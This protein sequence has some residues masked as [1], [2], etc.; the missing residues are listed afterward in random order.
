MENTTTPFEKQLSLWDSDWLDGVELL[1]LSDEDEPETDD[2]YISLPDEC[3]DEEA[4]VEV[5]DVLSR[6]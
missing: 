6:W 1:P 5:A 4:E 2:P 3:D